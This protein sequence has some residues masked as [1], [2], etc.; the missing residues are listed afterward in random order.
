MRIL[1]GLLAAMLFASPA[2]AYS[3]TGI[4][5]LDA[6]LSWLDSAAG[7]IEGGEPTATTLEEETTTTL[8]E[9]TTTLEDTTTTL[10]ETTTTTTTITATTNT[11]APAGACRITE[12][13]PKAT[14]VYYCSQDNQIMVLT[15]NFICRNP[16][17]QSEC[18]GIQSKPRIHKTCVENE[19]CVKGLDYC[20]KPEY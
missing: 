6:I 1:A 19:R 10:E 2:A 12:D 7:F 14:T 20:V 15:T 11:L 3:G 9:T 4:C 18:K 13:C 8:G 16:G 5:F 17:P